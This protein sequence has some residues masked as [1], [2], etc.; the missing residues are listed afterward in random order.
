MV[1]RWRWPWRGGGSCR[2]GCRCSRRASAHEG[3]EGVACR[4]VNLSAALRRHRGRY[5][6][7]LLL[8]LILFLLVLLLGLLLLVSVCPCT[9][10]IVSVFLVLP[11][12]LGFGTRCSP[13]LRSLLL[14]CSIFLSHQN[15][16][17]R[18]FLDPSSHSSLFLF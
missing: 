9:P 3:K 7:L 8:L 10:L 17:H 15:A 1:G 16:L 6:F 11:V 5:Y 2:R 12:P 18:H 4:V 14:S 13:L